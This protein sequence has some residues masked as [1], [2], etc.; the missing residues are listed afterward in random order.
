VDD[1]DRALFAAVTRVT[2]QNGRRAKFWTSSWLDGMSSAAMFPAL[3]KQSKRKNC[4][5]ADAMENDNWIRDIMQNISAKLF[6]D[7]V[8]LWILVDDAALDPTQQEEDTITWTRTASG[9]YS[10]KSAYRMQFYD[11]VES[12]Y[13]TKVWQVWAPSRCKFFIWLMLQNRVWTTDRL[14]LKEWPKQY[15][16]QLCRRNLESVHHLF[17]ECP[18]ARQVWIEISSFMPSS[19]ELVS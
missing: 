10:A 19:S 5:V 1:V 11:S 2:V 7:Y 17:M 6:V 16:Y 12:T 13:P 9:E 14:L 15:F 4:S 3:F 8:M 18:V